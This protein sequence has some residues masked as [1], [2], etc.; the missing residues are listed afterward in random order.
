M[1]RL[2][3]HIAQE[4]SRYAQV[5]VLGPKGSASLAPEEVAIDE[6]TSEKMG[7]F[8]LQAFLRC[9]RIARRWRPDIIMAGSG[10]TAPIAVIVARFIGARAVVYAHGLDLTVDHAVYRRVWLPLVARADTVIVNSSAT[11]EL[12]LR[13]G[14]RSDRL[15]IVHPGVELPANSEPGDLQ[16]L[17]E[18]RRKHDLGPGKLLISVGR[19]TPR[20]GILEFVRDVLPGIVARVPHCTLVIV[21]D[22]PVHALAAASQSVES[23]QAVARQASVA[24]NIRFLGKITDDEL[25][26]VYGIANLHVFPVQLRPNDPEGFGMVAIEAAARGVA[27]VAYR[28][29]G[30]PDAV[31]ENQSGRLINPGDSSGFASAAIALLERPLDADAIAAFAQRFSWDRV[32]KQLAEALGADAQE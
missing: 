1:E 16:D 24:A 20:K 9:L 26:M 29:G 5:R 7:P 27:T 22:A 8:L 4:L 23:I 6:A 25:S 15:R 21:G 17:A 32:G 13:A 12:A 28:V 31:A 10:L 11:R 2:N 3:W 14:V 19:L 30:V 18:F